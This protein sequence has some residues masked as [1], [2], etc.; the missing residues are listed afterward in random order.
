MILNTLKRYD[1]TARVLQLVHLSSGAL[2]PTPRETIS[3]QVRLVNKLGFAEIRVKELL[4][5]ELDFLW[6]DTLAD[7]NGTLVFPLSGYEE[8]GREF[9]TVTVTPAMDPFGDLFEWVYT[10]EHD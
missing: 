4:Q 9:R 10:V 1:H 5:Y 2:Q 7:R 6:F 3:C 8:K